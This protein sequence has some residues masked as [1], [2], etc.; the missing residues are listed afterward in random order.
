MSY[1]VDYSG[2]H[3]HVDGVED[4][5]YSVTSAAVKA[6]RASAKVGDYGGDFGVTAEDLVFTIWHSTSVRI[7]K[8]ATLTDSDNRVYSIVEIVSRRADGVQ[9]VVLGRLQP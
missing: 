6:R 5:T 2:D 7:A 4:L 9:T 1:V 8:D 3:A